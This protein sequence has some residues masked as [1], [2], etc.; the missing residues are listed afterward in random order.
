VVSRDHD[1]HL[2]M[3]KENMME[4]KSLPKLSEDKFLHFKKL[5][6][7]YIQIEALLRT[8]SA[9]VLLGAESHSIHQA[10]MGLVAITQAKSTKES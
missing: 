8:Q 2:G 6:E 9:I 7:E 5:N 3:T 10:T 1:S 4:T